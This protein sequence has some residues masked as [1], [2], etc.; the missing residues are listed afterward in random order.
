[1]SDVGQ[2]AALADELEGFLTAPNQDGSRLAATIG[3]AMDPRTAA[4]IDGIQKPAVVICPLSALSTGR[5][6]IG[7]RFKEVE[8]TFLVAVVTE[9]TFSEQGH[10]KAV[11]EAW[12]LVEAARDRIHGQRSYVTPSRTTWEW[13][14]DQFSPADED[15][16]HCVIVS[17][18]TT[19]GTVGN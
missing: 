8:Y 19:P 17:R 13:D 11:A 1:M 9:A 15:D 2:Y 3:R 4:Q 6:T 14:G 12:A 16:A 18:Y 5:K 7:N 10:K